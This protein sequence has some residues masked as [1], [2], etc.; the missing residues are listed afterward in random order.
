MIET[1]AAVSSEEQ[2]GHQEPKRRPCV[3]NAM[4]ESLPGLAKK[5]SLILLDSPD[6]CHVSVSVLFYVVLG[7]EPMTSC[8]PGECFATEPQPRP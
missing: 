7:M 3:L 2:H 4:C 6:T 1:G 5:A 8:M